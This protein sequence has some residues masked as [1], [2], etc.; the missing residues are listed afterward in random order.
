MDD[1]GGV[2]G[3]GLTSYARLSCL[4]VEVP[5]D[6]T[7]YWAEPTSYFLA[8]GEKHGQV[9]GALFSVAAAA[10]ADQLLLV[11]LLLLTSCYSCCCC[12]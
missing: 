7:D 10:E 11:L 2:D 1:P 4:E 5:Q 3:P 9:G 6:L 12:C 8:P